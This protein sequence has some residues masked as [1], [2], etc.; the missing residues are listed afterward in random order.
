MVLVV[1]F[2]F[3]D[4]NQVIHLPLFLWPENPHFSVQ[5]QS[6]FYGGGMLVASV[7]LKSPDRTF[8]SQ[9]FQGRG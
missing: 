8:P 2:Q 6:S 5:G 9:F 3:Q 4:M 1:L 7:P